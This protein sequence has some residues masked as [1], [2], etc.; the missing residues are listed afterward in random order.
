[1]KFAWFLSGVGQ[2]GHWPAVSAWDY[3]EWCFVADHFKRQV[4]LASDEQRM[5]TD[6]FA[7]SI[8]RNAMKTIRLESSQKGIVVFQ[9]FVFLVAGAIGAPVTKVYWQ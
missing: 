1:L 3:Q 2:S 8:N 6:V 9:C 4:S 5:S 7:K